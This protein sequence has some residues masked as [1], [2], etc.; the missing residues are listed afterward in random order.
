V[1][2][3]DNPYDNAKAE[4]FMKALHVEAAHPMA[5]QSF[6]KVADSLPRFFKSV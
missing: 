5:T 2:R 3:R 4:D 1:G 6:A